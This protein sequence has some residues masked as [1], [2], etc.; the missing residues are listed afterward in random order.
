MLISDTIK[1]FLEER[2]AMRYSPHT[3]RDYTVTYKKFLN[4]VGD[5]EFENIQKQHIIRFMTSQSNVSAK[6]LR[7]YH[8]E[9]SALWQW[10]IQ[11]G[12]CEQ[13]P[14]RQIK[15]PIAE[16]KTVVPLSRAEILALLESAFHSPYPYYSYRDRAI[17]F[18]LLDTGI[19]ATELC[20][21]QIKDLNRVTRHIRVVGKGRKERLVPISEETIEAIEEYLRM[22]GDINHTS[23]LFALKSG[24]PMERCKLR[25]ILAEI[26]HKSG[27]SHVFPHRFR[28][29]FAIQF[30]R[31]GGNIYLLQ[32]ILGHSTLDM[33]KRYLAIA[34][35]DID[36]DHAIASPVKCWD[37]A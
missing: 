30:L 4:H 6:T 1:Q 23:P 24:K 17:I 29:T 22:R 19:R 13:N 10:A 37:L 32:K 7:N 36:H 33:V 20:N 28:H 27:V 11:Q 21:L 2:I 5:M 26:G 35:H 31:N 16:K 25:K 34:Q 15:A 18:T 3:I 9:L 14:V 12:I 8:A